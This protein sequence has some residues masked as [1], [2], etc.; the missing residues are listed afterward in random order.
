MAPFA[1]RTHAAAAIRMKQIALDDHSRT[2]RRLRAKL[3]TERRFSSIIREELD[4]KIV[5]MDRELELVMKDNCGL[6]DS[7]RIYQEREK[8]LH[9]DIVRRITQLEELRMNHHANLVSLEGCHT[10]NAGL[11]EISLR[12]SQKI[13][14][15]K[16]KKQYMRESHSL[17][18]QQMQATIQEIEGTVQEQALTID[19]LID[20]NTSLLQTI[21]DLQ[22]GG[23]IPLEDDRRSIPKEALK[24][25]N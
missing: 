10:T 1:P 21:Q 5:S 9:E 12:L 7:L 8:T 24:N 19:A 2:I 20:E 18:H 3:A 17:Y 4:K 14:R 25:S 22:V 16:A 13:A 15:L 11:T 6:R 23:A